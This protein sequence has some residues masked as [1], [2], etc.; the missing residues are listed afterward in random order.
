MPHREEGEGRQ[1]PQD[2]GQLR[3]TVVRK[4]QC[5]QAAQLQ[6]AGRQRLQSVEAQVQV[7]QAAGQVTQASRQSGQGTMEAGT[8]GAPALAAWKW[9]RDL[10]PSELESWFSPDCQRK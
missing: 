8:Q 1:G 5:I 6:D 3:E 7:G 4:Q 2:L 9:R 10:W